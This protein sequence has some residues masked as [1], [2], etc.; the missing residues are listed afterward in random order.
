MKTTFFKVLIGIFLLA[1]L[2]MAE[3]I[4]FII[5]MLKGRIFNL[6]LKMWT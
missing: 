6:K 3:Y 5:N 1:N 4:K 2:G